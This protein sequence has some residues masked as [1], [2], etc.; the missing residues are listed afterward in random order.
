MSFTYISKDDT[1]NFSTY[2]G[3]FNFR[4]YGTPEPSM[5]N[6]PKRCCSSTLF[7]QRKVISYFMPRQN[8]QWDNLVSWGNPT[9]SRKVNKV[10]V[11]I[12]KHEVW[13]TG[14]PTSAHHAVKWQEYVDVLTA[15]CYICL[16]KPD[17]SIL[18]SGT[19]G[20]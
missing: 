17:A 16:S 12:K 14:V 7:Y 5:N 10:I 1:F 11:D 8:M 13:V 4:A 15:T 19:C 20:Q 9:K 2:V 6:L 18:L 3:Y